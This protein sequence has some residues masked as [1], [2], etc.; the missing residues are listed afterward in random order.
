M[1]SKL[2]FS[3]DDEQLQLVTISNQQLLTTVNINHYTAFLDNPQY[4]TH[5]LLP[6]ILHIGCS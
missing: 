1:K 3:H 6:P 2:G 5:L 4:F